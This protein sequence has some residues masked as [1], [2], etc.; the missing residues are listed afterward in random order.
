MTLTVFLMEFVYPQYFYK[1]IFPVYEVSLIGLYKIV[2]H[3]LTSQNKLIKQS[4]KYVLESALL[5]ELHTSGHIWT[6]RIECAR[7][8]EQSRC[9]T[10]LSNSIQREFR[11]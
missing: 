7:S 2:Y 3:F 11:E 4:F 5:C 10:Q 6:A 9:S 1:T 8:F